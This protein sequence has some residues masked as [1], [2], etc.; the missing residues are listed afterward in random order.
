[1]ESIT[2]KSHKKIGGLIV[3]LGFLLSPL[4]WWNDLIINIPLAYLIA[5]GLTLFFPGYFAMF[6]ILGYWLTNVLGLVLMH[7]GGQ[8]VIHDDQHPYNIHSVI[9]HLSIS[10]VYSL[11]LG[12]IVMTGILKL[13]TEYF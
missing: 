3:L 6:M 9:K 7:R 12:I 10:L 1:M 13:P 5:T 8:L 4:S 11:I 2:N